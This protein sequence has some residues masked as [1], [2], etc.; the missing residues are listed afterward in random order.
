[1]IGSKRGAL[2]GLLFFLVPAFPLL[3]EEPPFSISRS[4]RFF[5][6]RHEKRPLVR[7]VIGRG[8]EDSDQ[9]PKRV[10]T[11]IVDP[12]QTETPRFLTKGASDP[13]P[14]QNGVFLGWQTTSVDGLGTANTWSLPGDTRQTFDR[15]LRRE[16]TKRAAYLT[17]MVQWEAEGQTLLRE[18]RTLVVHAPPSKSAL[19]FDQISTLRAT[20]GNVTLKGTSED[21][22]LQVRLNKNVTK[23]RS[24]KYM[25]PPARELQK[26]R[27]PDWFAVQFQIDDRLCTIQ[28]LSNPS[29]PDGK[30]ISAYRKNG[31]FGYYT[32]EQIKKGNDSTHHVRFFVRTGPLPDTKKKMSERFNTYVRQLSGDEN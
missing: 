18:R 1:M 14:H 16:T 20:E 6:V 24:A 25:Y 2:I 13:D 8:G 3:A 17:V 12:N 11:H 31:R 9:T 28:M 32:P 4:D 19:L 27:V 29:H 21:A 23:N 26:D 10:F 15:V 22:G 30:Q 5:E 7:L